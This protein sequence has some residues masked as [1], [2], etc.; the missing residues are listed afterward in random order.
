M[1]Q[2][3]RYSSTGEPNEKWV[4]GTRYDRGLLG[5]NADGSG[6]F[7]DWQI[8]FEDYPPRVKVW[9]ECEYCHRWSSE[10]E[11]WESELI[12]SGPTFFIQETDKK[13]V[14]YWRYVATEFCD[15]CEDE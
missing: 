4:D 3:T 13:G 14:P 9:S 1:E 5:V 11:R 7:S 2:V 10:T 12:E 6:R 8:P 15:K